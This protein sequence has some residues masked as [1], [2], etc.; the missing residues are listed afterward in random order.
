MLAEDNNSFP[1]TAGNFISTLVTYTA[2]ASPPCGDLEI[3]LTGLKGGHGEP[4]RFRFGGPRGHRTPLIPATTYTWSNSGTAWS[5]AANWGGAVPASAGV[6]LFNLNATYAS[7]PILTSTA[8]VGGLWNT[9]SGAVTISGRPRIRLAASSSTATP[10]SA[11][12]WTRG[13]AA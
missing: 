2:G 8:A 7:Q 12:R 1:I 6:G 9:G 11:S 13:P 3:R 4:D 5:S 10:L